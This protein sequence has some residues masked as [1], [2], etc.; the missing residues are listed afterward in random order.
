MADV[1]IPLLAGLF[2]ASSPIGR[3]W[4]LVLNVKFKH[5]F[6]NFPNSAGRTQGLKSQMREIVISLIWEKGSA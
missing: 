2:M 4:R 6:L 3:N 1:P 5:L